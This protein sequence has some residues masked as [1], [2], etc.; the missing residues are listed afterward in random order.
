[1]PIALTEKELQQLRS[2]VPLH[3]LSDERFGELT[4]DLRVEFAPRGTDLF[5]EGDTAQEN[6]YLLDGQVGLMN[7]AATV[8]QIAAHIATEVATM[9]PGQQVLVRAFEGVGKGG[10]GTAIAR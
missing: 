7:G 6:V 10:I 1:M 3:M 5:R 2:L 4:A 9:R 8:E